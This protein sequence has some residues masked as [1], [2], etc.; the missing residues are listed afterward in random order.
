MVYYDLKRKRC[1][2][3]MNDLLEKENS[4]C[5]VFVCFFYLRKDSFYNCPRYFQLSN[6]EDFVI[7]TTILHFKQPDSS[8]G[9]QGEE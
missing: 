5:C 6:G 9:I 7:H 8:S 2:C 3:A 4:C 1:R